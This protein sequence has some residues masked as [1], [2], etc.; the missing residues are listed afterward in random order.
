MP[1]IPGTGNPAAFGGWGKTKEVVMETTKKVIYT[2][3]LSAKLSNFA[4][5]AAHIAACREQ[6]IT[7]LSEV[8]SNPGELVELCHQLVMT[9]GAV[10]RAANR[11][12]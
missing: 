3:K 10:I 5:S 12:K 4:D 9:E 1:Y 6:L 7:Q 11:L 8:I 2:R